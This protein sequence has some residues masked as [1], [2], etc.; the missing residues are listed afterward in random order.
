MPN[1][2]HLLRFA[3]GPSMGGALTWPYWSTQ[4]LSGMLHQPKLCEF[5]QWGTNS[6]FLLKTYNKNKKET[7]PT[8]RSAE[9]W[10]DQEKLRYE[11][12]ASEIWPP[13]SC[14]SSSIHIGLELLP[15]LGEL[16]K[17]IFGKSWEFGPTGLIPPQ[18]AL[19]GRVL[20]FFYK[21]CQPHYT[22][23]QFGLLKPS[24]NECT[25]YLWFLGSPVTKNGPKMAKNNCK[26]PPHTFLDL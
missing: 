11:L 12:F 23:P 5:I 2:K 26:S 18:S 7:L 25:Q 19:K 1:F 4:C 6:G 10:Q 24:S 21:R 3:E 20:T 14:P 16:Q 13:L 17:Q 9:R 8:Q 15:A 22:S